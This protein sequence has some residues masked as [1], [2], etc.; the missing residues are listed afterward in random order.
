M[1]QEEILQ[2]LQEKLENHPEVYQAIALDG[3]EC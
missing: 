1:T 2:D 3:V